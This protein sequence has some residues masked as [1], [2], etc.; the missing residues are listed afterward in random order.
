MPGCPPPLD[1]QTQT[2]SVDGRTPRACPGL[3]EFALADADGSYGCRA[4][5]D[6]QRQG[7][8]VEPLLEPGSVAGNFDPGDAAGVA[9]DA[10]VGNSR[11]SA[12][13][14]R[15]GG[16]AHSFGQPGQAG[17][18]SCAPN[19]RDRRSQPPGDWVDV[20]DGD[21]PAE[22]AVAT[23][24]KSSKEAAAEV[25]MCRR[26]R[27]SYRQELEIAGSERDDP[28]VRAQ[29]LVS[30]ARAG[31]KPKLALDPRGRRIKI[32]GR[33]DDMVDPHRDTKLPVA[34]LAANA[35]WPPSE[36]REHGEVALLTERT[37]ATTALA[38]RTLP[39]AATTVPRA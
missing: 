33:V 17:A 13:E 14:E 28:V 39:S 36:L 30:S 20:V 9:V 7:G 26:P 23:S 37:R 2:A 8:V 32:D 15:Q 18:Q 29:A 25:R 27:I 34:Q 21:G 11:I 35:A 16:L 38:G 3:P 24:C 1:Q 6:A 10:R 4:G 19:R 31:D 5:D 22:Q 12:D